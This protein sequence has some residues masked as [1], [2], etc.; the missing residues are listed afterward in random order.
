[1]DLNSKSSSDAARFLAWAGLIVLLV[2]HLDSWRPK[3]DLIW[4]GWMPEELA[5]RLVWMGLAFLYLIFFCN[6]IW[7]ED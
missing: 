2:L 5:W 6:R 1:M 7:K 4:F 3:R